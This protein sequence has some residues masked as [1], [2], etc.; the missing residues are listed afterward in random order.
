M[1]ASHSSW[2]RVTDV[3]SRVASS[4]AVSSRSLTRGAPLAVVGPWGTSGTCIGTRGDAG[5]S[6]TS[7]MRM[8]TVDSAW[9]TPLSPSPCCFLNLAIP[10][11]VLAGITISVARVDRFAAQLARQVALVVARCWRPTRWLGCSSAGISSCCPHR[12]NTSLRTPVAWGGI[13]CAR[14]QPWRD[15]IVSESAI[16]VEF[17][18]VCDEICLI[19]SN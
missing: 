4:G 2:V 9:Q 7:F 15:K 11:T 5:G 1:S 8:G 14:L 10:T 6:A 17:M 3:R 19:V 13:L 12:S 16:F 18:I